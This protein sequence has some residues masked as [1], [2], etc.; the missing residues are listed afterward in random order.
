MKNALVLKTMFPSKEMAPD[1]IEGIYLDQREVSRK[2]VYAVETPSGVVI[3]LGNHQLDA[4]MEDLEIGSIVKLSL[5]P[6]VE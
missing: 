1:F 2:K 5:T 3:L 4:Q 6:I